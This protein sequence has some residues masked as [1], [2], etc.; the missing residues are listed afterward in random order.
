[1]STQ[2]RRPD[3]ARGTARSGSQRARAKNEAVVRDAGAPG[4]ILEPGTVPR[5]DWRTD[6][7]PPLLAFVVYGVPA[8]QGSKRAGVGRGGKVFMREQS[9]YV[10]PWRRAVKEMSRNAIRNYTKRTGQPW[11]PI[12]GGALITAT[13]TVPATAAATDRGDTYATGSPDL[14]KM[15]RA[16]GDA[17]SPTPVSAADVKDVPEP[18]R[19]AAREKMMA[20]RRKTAVMYD[21]ARIVVW[22]N[23]SK[24]YPK[25]RPDSLGYSGVVIQVWDM[26]ALEDAERRPVIYM[27]GTPH[28]LVR[29]L[30]TWARPLTG[31]VWAEAAHRVTQ[32]PL[33]VLEADD[34]VHLKGRGITDDGVRAVLRHMLINGPDHPLKIIDSRTPGAATA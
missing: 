18:M 30:Q 17:I 26:R 27:S 4:H 19:K 3:P 8:G 10:A 24:V 32:D 29:D 2:A 7:V 34:H 23:V 33:A 1:M 11:E 15:E 22:D 12:S 25:T 14:D 9:D 6:I 13:V 20:E 16:I 21:D 5:A 31:E 28:M